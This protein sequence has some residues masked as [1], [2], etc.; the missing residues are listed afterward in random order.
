[1]NERIK[2][3]DLRN[4]QNKLFFYENPLPQTNL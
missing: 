4:K 2:N 1:M 3:N